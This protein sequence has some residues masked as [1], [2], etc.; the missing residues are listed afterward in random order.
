MQTGWQKSNGK[1]Y[2]MNSYGAMQT[3]WQKIGGKWYYFDEESGAMATGSVTINGITYYFKG[4]G[5]WIDPYYDVSLV[6]VNKVKQY[7]PS[8]GYYGYEVSGN[9]VEVLV[10]R[11]QGDGA[12]LMGIVVNLITGKATCNG[13]GGYYTWEDFYG[14]MPYSFY[15]W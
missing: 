13:F 11:P 3:G 10:S 2:Y 8:A 12:I 1:W 9:T 5:S 7:Y 6:V 4:D 14:K 15:I